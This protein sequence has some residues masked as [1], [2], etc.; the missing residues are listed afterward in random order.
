MR[1]FK[2]IEHEQVRRASQEASNAV[3]LVGIS[4][5]NAGS[6]Y[7]ARVEGSNGCRAPPP[8]YE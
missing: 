5:R 4:T 1:I 3:V 8:T 2:R 6:E 7:E